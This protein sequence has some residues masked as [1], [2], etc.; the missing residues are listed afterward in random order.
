MITHHIR[1]YIPVN[2][3]HSEVVYRLIAAVEIVLNFC[4]KL[5]GFANIITYLLLNIDY[6]IGCVYSPLGLVIFMA[7][8]RTCVCFSNRSLAFV[9]NSCD[10]YI[11]HFRKNSANTSRWSGFREE[12][13]VLSCYTLVISHLFLHL[14]DALHLDSKLFVHLFLIYTILLIPWQSYSVHLVYSVVC[15]VDIKTCLNWIILYH[16]RGKTIRFKIM[17]N[18]F[19]V[20][21]TKF[22]HHLQHSHLNKYIG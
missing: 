22:A 21:N 3:N 15:D 5:R 16:V 1:I 9:S 12:A 11:D 4:A 10:R 6:A 13:N 14:A 20:L 19:K 8:E 2:Q 17:F 18:I 7:V